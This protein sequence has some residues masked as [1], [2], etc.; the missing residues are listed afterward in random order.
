MTEL[1][2]AY[3]VRPPEALSQNDINSFGIHSHPEM[4]QSNIFKD[5]LSLCQQTN[6]KE[7]LTIRVVEYLRGS[8]SL[9]NLNGFGKEWSYIFNHFL[10]TGNQLNKEKA[11]QIVKASNIEAFLGKEKN[12]YHSA[13]TTVAD[14]M[15]GLAYLKKLSFKGNIDYQFV[16]KTM[17][18]VEDCLK[19]KFDLP[20]I[21]IKPYFE[22]PVLLPPCF[23]KLDPCDTKRMEE[24]IFPFLEDIFT[25]RPYE[26]P[27][28]SGCVSDGECSCKTNDE[29]V[30]QNTCCAKIQLNIIDLM[31]VKEHTKCYQ[32][33][34][35][36]YIKN[37]L[38]GESLETTHRRLER[39]EEF[40]ETEESITTFEEKY[41]QTEE[42]ASLKK[43]IENV[44]KKDSAWD[45]GLTTNSSFGIPI[46]AANLS[47]G[48][49]STT[50]F[51]G[52]ESK[53][54]TDKDVRDYSKEVVERATKNVEERVRRLASTRRLFE[55]EE[56]N[57]HSFE[58]AGGANISGQYLYVNKISKAQ[59]YNY[60]KKAA[61][62]IYLPEPASLLKKLFEN[63]FSGIKPIAP[64]PIVIDPKTITPENY[65][66]LII[67]Y[68]LKDVP[69]PPDFITEIS[70]TLEGEMGDPAHGG[71]GSH[72]FN[73]PCTIPAGYFTLEMTANIIRLNYNS[74]GGVSISATLGPNGNNVSHVDG[75][76][77][78][79]HSSLPPLEG[80]Q[81]VIVHT[82]DVTNFTWQLLIK[83]ALSEDAKL[84]WQ[85]AV[86]DK[87]IEAYEKE[88]AKYQKDLEKYEKELRE[89][90]EKEA[91]LK[92]ARNNRN[93]FINREVER[94]EL[95]RMVISYISCQFYD[96]FDAMKSRVKPCG[97]PEMDIKEAEEEGKFIQFFEQAF[98][99]NL[100]T[101]IFYPYFW[102]RKCTWKDKLGEESNDLI[103]QK[104]LSAGSCRVLIPLRD[105]FYNYMQYFLATGE[106]WGQS[107]IPPLPNDP[108]YVSIA[109]EIKE[110]K[111]N[112]FAD[113]EGTIDAINGSNIVTLKGTN[114]Y[115][116]FA[117]SNAIPPILAGLNM[118]SI[119]ADIDREIIIDCK[120]YRIVDIQPNTSIP[121][122]TSWF[123]TLDRNYEGNSD[124]NA[125][126][127]MK[128]STGAVFIGA[129]WEV[130][131]PT[132]LTFLRDKSQCLP[133]YPLKECKEL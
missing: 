127:N 21:S 44:I 65:K 86:Y 34:D 105:G 18:F 91:E 94:T 74:G 89:F 124:P 95:K 123:I 106:I 10:S 40:T 68:G 130:V 90:E 60:G 77:V 48:T 110:Q 52:S 80:N 79:L 23:F 38:D 22:R 129:P 50:N 33:G 51:S 78:S 92:A 20:Q 84:E 12:N 8:Q 102:G 101:Y 112:Y 117:N 28:A 59:V 30:D 87:I 103:F 120:V 85:T 16:L 132:T 47:F 63:K 37:I 83:C 72:I 98:N 3:A 67:Q 36:S 107:G 53:T 109:Q 108:Q 5:W 6:K 70:V 62:N 57:K 64:K 97:Y 42:K 71:S 128:W 96:Q 104:F 125:N 32:A 19:Y 113:R 25:T 82:W 76:S 114:H 17:N 88:L 29:C 26:M 49:N 31:L 11:A 99:W 55:T 54:I 111:G 61:V 58:N 81:V 4:Y 43:E 24:N 1:I 126:I 45:A 118:L 9:K 93:P 46:G 73:F 14:T 75:G 13:R 116:T 131:T 35:L 15:L 122:F 2:R 27:R 100:M 133:C 119:N 39:T 69:L 115:W 66:D 121:N 56:T 7:L 41:L